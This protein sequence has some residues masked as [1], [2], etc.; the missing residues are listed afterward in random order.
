LQ[1]AQGEDAFARPAQRLARRVATGQFQRTVSLHRG[2][3][4]RRTAVVDIETAVWQLPFENRPAGFL[5]AR[6]R[7]RIPGGAIRLVQPQLQQDVIGFE[8]GIG[9]QFAAPETLRRLAAQERI[10]GAAD[11]DVEIRRVLDQAPDLFGM[12][13]RDAARRFQFRRHH[14]TSMITT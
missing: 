10:G 2:A 4:F 14:G 1:A 6:A 3:D 13:A 5:D 12:A 11:L 9:C 8:G 7:G